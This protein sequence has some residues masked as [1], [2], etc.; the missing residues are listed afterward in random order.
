[1]VERMVPALYV[2]DLAL[3]KAF[4]CDL[5]G[6]KAAFEADWIVQLADPE[7]EA[8]EIILQ[9]R[10]HDLIPEAFRKAPQGCSIAFVVPDCDEHYQKALSMGLE[11]IQ[12]PRDEYYGQRRFLTVD[13]DG[14]LVDVSSNCDPSPEF[15]AKYF[16]SESA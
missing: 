8:V 10:T 12:E 7:N 9:P 13:P 2:Y 15:M 11:I 16:E 1:M 14:L 3:S 5:L 4:Y 6:L